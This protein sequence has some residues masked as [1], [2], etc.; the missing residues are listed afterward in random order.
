MDFLLIIIS[1]LLCLLTTFAVLLRFLS[2]QTPANLPPGPSRL[3]IIGNLHNLGDKPHKSLAHLASIHG[4]L[5][6][7]KLGQVTTIVASSPSVAKEILQKHDLVLSDRQLIL[8]IRAHDHH[9]HGLPWVPVGPKWRNLRKVCNTYLFTTQKLD[10]NQ[11]LRRK[12][13][14]E[15]LEAVR[16]NACENKAVDIGKAAFMTT[17]GALSTTVLSLDLTDEA[18][19]D[20]REFKEVARC[21]M[22]EAGKPNLGDYFP[23]LGK[24][25]LQGIHRR[26]S[27]YFG[28]VL[29]LFGRIIE[30][31]LKKRNSEAYVSGNDMLDTLLDIVD[32]EN[33]DASMDLDLI[34]HLDLFVAGTDTTSSTLEWAIVELLRNPKTFTKAREELNLTIG[35]DKHLQESDILRLPYLQAILKE[36]FRLHP[37]IPL[38]LP[39]KAG[40][41]VEVCGFTVPKGAQIMVNAWAIGRDPTTWDNPNSF[42]PERFMGSEVDVR[43]NS[44]ELIPFGGGRRICPGLPLAMRMLHMMLGSLIHSFDWK[45]E[46]GVEPE[47]L[48]M[49]EKFGI[50]L[51]KAKP[52]FAVPVNSRQLT[53]ALCASDHHKFGMSL[54]PMGSKWR[55]LR[56]VC[57]TYLFSTQKLDSNQDIRR[58][59]IQELVESVRQSASEGKAVDIGGAI[60]RATLS[61]IS[62]TVLSL[63]LNDGGSEDV[64]EFKEAT[65]GI[66]K[67][68]G[69]PN[70]GDYFPF[71]GFMDLQGIQ[72]RMRTHSGKVL[73][74]FGRI[75][76]ERLKKRKSMKYVSSN[77]MLD[78]LLDIVDQENQDASMNLDLIKHLFLDLFVA[79]T[80]TVTSTIEWAMAELLRNPNAFAKAKEEL[81]KTIGKDN[82]LHES[83]IMRLP[84]L[85]AIIKENFRLHPAGPLLVPRKAG[86]EVEIF[87]FTVPK[88]SQ[89]IINAW[90]MGRDPTIWD[91]PNFFRPERFIG[92]EI[93]VGGNNFELI[94][95]GGGRRICPGLPL[96]MRMLHMMLG[97]LVHWF[98]WK[99]V[100]GVDP[101]SLDMEEKFGITLQKAKP[102][103]V[104]P[105]PT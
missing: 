6:T 99:L 9:E 75:I 11:E 84:F 12:K 88:G 93:D 48:D 49:D 101:M 69:K 20:A 54:L 74:L 7:L 50:S 91:N 32:Q 47:D 55:N 35:K 89:V 67:E 57:N 23:V 38:L 19:E 4:P 85:R 8:A 51:Q 5:M 10:S 52:L 63:D 53:L 42:M 46:D 71:M 83:D 59:K 100:D 68:A 17:F 15:L 14:Q 27:T 61:A 72:R 97:S 76:D 24:L 81:H 87:G 22:D 80:D 96:A 92:S 1:C 79:G 30:E 21:I 40:A 13:I 43:G 41:D 94:P 70:L 39:R 29:N 78:T 28:K 90:A 33:R 73:N 62:M 44:F 105:T 77:D 34:K 18:S 64:V 31:R 37:A 102:L 98:N 3:P 45:L 60:F 86:S 65:W 104:F 95:F 103:I 26:M 66:M 56:K 25:D 82:H 36:T 16:R 2:T 58:K